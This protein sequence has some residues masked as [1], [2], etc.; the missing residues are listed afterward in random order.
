MTLKRQFVATLATLALAA[1]LLLAAPVRAQNDPKT[2]DENA[3]SREGRRDGA[4][5]GVGVGIASVNNVGET[6]FTAALR[7]RVGGRRGD[8]DRRSGDRDDN[9]DWRGRQPDGG[10]MR[11]YFEPEVGYWKASDKNG[12]GSDLLLGV[13]LVG[14]VPL[15]SV[16]TFIGIGVGAHRID[17]T[18]LR[19]ADTSGTQTKAGVNAQFG[20]DVYLTRSLSLF[21]TGRFDLVQDARNNLQTKVYLGLRGRF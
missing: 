2:D 5:L 10:G 19:N 20:L 17:A 3:D 16:D 18:L 13:N 21:G 1:G 7:L 9:P 12:G 14:V 8:G 11:G 4:S 15:S 6:Y